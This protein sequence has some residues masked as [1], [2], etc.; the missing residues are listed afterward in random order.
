[1]LFHHTR[2]QGAH[3]C[4]LCDPVAQNLAFFF[5][6]LDRMDVHTSMAM[7]LLEGHHPKTIDL[8][9]FLHLLLSRLLLLLVAVL[10]QMISYAEF[11]LHR[12]A[13]HLH[14]YETV[15]LPNLILH[16]A[17]FLL[18]RHRGFC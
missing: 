12:D 13:Q 1:M 2:A 7:G 8:D 4:V 6:H 17:E 16:G 5:S 11:L 15:I 3:H 9:K 18:R 14:R 10:S